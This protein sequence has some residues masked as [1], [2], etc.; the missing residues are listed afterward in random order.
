MCPQSL[1]GRC[2]FD[3]GDSP[4]HGRFQNAIQRLTREIGG[5]CLEFLDKMLRDLPCNRFER[6]E[7]WNFSCA[8]DKNVPDEKRSMAAARLG[9]RSRAG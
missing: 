3:P 1:S 5:A 4:N 6:D 8:K 9:S 7:I 2:Q